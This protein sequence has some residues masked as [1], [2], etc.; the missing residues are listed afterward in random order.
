[1]KLRELNKRLISWQ[2]RLLL[3]SCI[4]CGSAIQ[5]N[6]EIC[7]ACEK[8]FKPID[9]ACPICSSPAKNSKE[10]G[11][12]QKDPP[13]FSQTIAMFEYSGAIKTLI[14]RM[15]YHQDNFA[16]HTAANLFVHKLQQHK[17][18]AIPNLII[19]VPIHT[20]RLVHRG[21]NQSAEITKVVANEL[22]CPQNPHMITKIKHTSSQQSLPL[23][24]R[25]SNVRGA[26]STT[27][28]LDGQSIAILDDVMTSGETLRELS[29][30][31]TKAGARK[32]VCWVIAR[33]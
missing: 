22:Q 7:P 11:R 26:F 23:G 17:Y 20:T 2:K 8:T 14:H 30:V 9:A 32:V 25:K 33:A 16:L 24:K 13:M 29:R 27:M 15:K 21:F 6:T 12:C 18:F 5:S 4:L 1:M 31:A 19:P 10:C 28:R 3:R